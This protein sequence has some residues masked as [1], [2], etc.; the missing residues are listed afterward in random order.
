MRNPVPILAALAVSAFPPL[1][2]AQNIEI[3][4][5]QERTSA[6]GPETS[7][8]PLDEQLPRPPEGHIG[9]IAKL[10]PDHET[11]GGNARGDRLD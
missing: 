3:N 5:A 11:Q 4:S 8:V 1:L 7:A 2:P 9:R 6:R 10:L